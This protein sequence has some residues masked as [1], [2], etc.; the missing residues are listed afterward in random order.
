[1]PGRVR[2]RSGPARPRARPP[3]AARRRRRGWRRRRP[4]RAA[5]W[6]PRC[7]PSDARGG[8]RGSPWAAGRPRWPW[9]PGWAWRWA[10]PGAWRWRCGRAWG[11]RVGGGGGRPRGGGGRA[12]RPGGEHVGRLGRAH[13]GPAQPR[14]GV[15]GAGP[16]GPGDGLGEGDDGPGLAPVGADVDVVGAAGVVRRRVRRVDAA[17]GAAHLRGATGGEE[18]GAGEA[19]PPHGVDRERPAERDPQ[20]AGVVPR[21]ALGLAV[22]DLGGHRAPHRY[23]HLAEPGGTV[24]P[25]VAGW[26]RRR[27]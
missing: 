2:G 22:D 8:S 26:R 1:M 14:H 21:G 10:P 20:G 24:G 23:L 3:S 13:G 5:G 4:G 27:V 16:G 9:P 15:G 7:C 18:L 12:G 11:S 19:H 25:P 6:S 17:R